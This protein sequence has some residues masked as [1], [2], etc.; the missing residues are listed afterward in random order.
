[1]AIDLKVKLGNKGSKGSKVRCKRGH[2]TL[3]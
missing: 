2:G 1:M 3:R